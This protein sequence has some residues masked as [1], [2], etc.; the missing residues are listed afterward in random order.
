MIVDAPSDQ[1]VSAAE[2]LAPV[3]SAR[4]QESDLFR[5]MPADL[6]SRV[7]STRLVCLA[8]PRSLGGLELDPE[9]IIRVIEMLSRADGAARSFVFDTVGE[10]WATCRA[11][12]DPSLEQRARMLLAPDQAMRAAVEA[13]DIIFRL[14]GAQA[15]YDGQPL[16][17]C[18]RDLHTADQHILFSA[19][20]DK[21]FSKLKFGIEQP[22]FM[23]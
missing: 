20:C 16:Q 13:V 23:I 10:L 12:E 3:L 7:K 18:F 21:A 4:S 14:A 8:L 9:T 6:V 15:V 1:I 2:E 22:T 19:N 11:G 17:R 5:S